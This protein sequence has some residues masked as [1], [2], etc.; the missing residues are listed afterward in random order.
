MHRHFSVESY[1]EQQKGLN[2]KV[3]DNE[4]SG[5]DSS[6]FVNDSLVNLSQLLKMEVLKEC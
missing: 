6:V 3:H 5:L 4:E 1:I 2:V